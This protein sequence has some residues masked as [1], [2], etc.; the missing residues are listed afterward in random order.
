[1]QLNGESKVRAEPQINRIGVDFQMKPENEGVLLPWS[2]ASEKLEKSTVYWVAS[3]RS[4][5]RPLVVPVWGVWDGE[6]F[7]LRINPYTRT[8]K[9]LQCN[10]NITVH[11][12]SGEDA[13]IFDTTVSM[14]EDS[15]RKNEVIEAFNNKYQ[16][17]QPK[18]AY[19]VGKPQ[20][21]QCQLCHG[22]GETAA[23][24]YR[25]TAT[26]YRWND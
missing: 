8:M 6:A 14:L 1:M 7:Y 2:R 20:V 15:E 5:G 11:L 3:T 12:E 26:K 9:N 22:I 13:V 10:P 18:A 17:P 4:D 24:E 25:S 21:A 16:F 19:F 23:N